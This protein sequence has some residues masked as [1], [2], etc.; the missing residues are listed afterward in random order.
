M[1]SDTYGTLL[2]SALPSTSTTVPGSSA[3]SVSSSHA[4]HYETRPPSGR[5]HQRKKRPVDNVPPSTSLDG[6]DERIEVKILPQDDHW[7]ETTATTCNAGNEDT[8]TNT[9]DTSLQ[10]NDHRHH[11]YF[12]PLSKKFHRRTSSLSLSQFALYLLCLIALISPVFFLSLPYALITSE[13][14]AI[15]DY[16]PFL[17]IAFKLLFLLLGTSLLFYRRRNVAHLPRIHLHKLCLILTLL[18]IIV[19]YWFYYIF[20]LLQPHVD[21][22]ER[23]LSFT[24]SY[25]DLL[26]FLLLLAVLIFEVKWLYPKWIVKVVRSPDGQTRQYTIGTH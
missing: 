10:M 25:E 8:L 11:D 22:Y 6:Q 9:N 17:T 19:A 14:I 2:S 23:I 18:T 4:I 20:K 21:K 1:E 15:E 13:A 24:S 12:Q 5:H 3:P 7:G 26:V 16:S